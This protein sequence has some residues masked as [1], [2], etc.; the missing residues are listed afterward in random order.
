[1]KGLDMSERVQKLI[2]S[3]GLCSRRA[4]E[5]LIEQGRVTINGTVAVLGDC[6]CPE[7]AIA[8][9]GRPLPKA[10]CYTYIMLNK[11][12]GYVTTMS[13]DRGRK[14]VAEL[15]SDLDVRVFP[16][17]RL[18]MDSEGLLLMTNDGELANRMTHPSHM[19][20]KVYHVRVKGGDINAA[21]RLMRKPMDIDGYTVG[22]AA[23]QVLKES[24]EDG[25]LLSV[26]ITEGR[27]R[28]VRKM[29]ERAGL[30]VLRLR[31]VAEGGLAL[32]SLPVGKW[33]FLSQTEISK[34]QK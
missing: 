26:T 31:R 8:V 28:Q 3:S 25:G 30:R 20:K 21:A 16:V 34:L 19:V 17:G 1:M 32:G 5:A 27:N 33:R 4:A 6:A 15:V 9:D 12:R 13:D 10:S 18:D 14:T 24:G 7:D 29:C 23:V 11:P 2:A 22:P